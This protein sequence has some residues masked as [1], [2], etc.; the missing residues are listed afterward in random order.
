ML[1]K[2]REYEKLLIDDRVEQIREA[3]LLLL[4]RLN[5]DL[6]SR[7]LIQ[8]LG[9][10]SPTIRGTAIQAL[11][12]FDDAIETRLLHAIENAPARIGRFS[13]AVLGLRDKQRYTPVVLDAIDATLSTVHDYFARTF[14]LGQCL[15]YSTFIL[16]VGYFE[17][18]T[19]VLL[20]EIF[21]LFS[22]LYGEKA[23]DVLAG[24]A[25]SGDSFL[26][27][28][29]RLRHWMQWQAR[30]S[31]SALRPSMTAM[32]QAHRGCCPCCR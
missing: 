26:C 29:R 4:R 16:L 23:F 3:E 18:Q 24:L 30:R 21:Y 17:E 1:P 14:T 12:D 9:D 7:V 28:S 15:G 25:K 20:E 6:A 27:I 31:P 32:P 2:L 11:R 8:A 5:N 19:R 22:I 10:H 13:S